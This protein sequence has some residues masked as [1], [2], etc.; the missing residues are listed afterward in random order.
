M[1]A[2]ANHVAPAAG[3]GAEPDAVGFAGVLPSPKVILLAATAA[4]CVSHW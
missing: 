4:A 1:S 2:E 3:P